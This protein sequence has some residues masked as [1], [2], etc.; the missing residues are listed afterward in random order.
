MTSL[1]EEPE[2]AAIQST[3]ISETHSYDVKDKIIDTGLYSVFLLSSSDS[4][5][6]ACQV[7]LVEHPPAK[8]ATDYILPLKITKASTKTEILKK[9]ADAV[10]KHYTDP[11]RPL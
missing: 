10:E 9:V 5:T 8:Q 3:D 11:D 6:D 4:I 7:L 2:S 1:Y